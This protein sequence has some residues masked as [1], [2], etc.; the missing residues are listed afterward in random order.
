MPAASID[1]L[2]VFPG[3]ESRSV[4]VLTGG[5]APVDLVWFLICAF[6]SCPGLLVFNAQYG[7]TQLR[8]LPS[9]LQP[10]GQSTCLVRTDP[11]TLQPFD[12]SLPPWPA[13]PAKS[14]MTHG[15][16]IGARYLQGSALALSRRVF[17]PVP[18]RH[19][20]QPVGGHACALLGRAAHSFIPSALEPNTIFQRAPCAIA[21]PTTLLWSQEPTRA[22]SRP[23]TKLKSSTTRTS[24]P[25]ALLLL[26]PP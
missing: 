18:R 6:P 23:L 17:V 8:C 14:S 11:V 12:G 15:T 16:I 25:P 3:H 9:D 7:S 2:F 19:H 24:C 22:A 13:S 4:G 1:A 5:E 26:F 10:C 20:G 21:K